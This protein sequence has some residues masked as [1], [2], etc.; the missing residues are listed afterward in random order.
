[1]REV[2]RSGGAVRGAAL[3]A[4]ALGAALFWTWS[5]AAAGATPPANPDRAES[6]LPDAALARAA[7][8]AVPA[9][10]AAQAQP[11]ERSPSAP[12]TGTITGTVRVGEQAV[13]GGFRVHL[14][15]R[16]S[17]TGTRNHD[18]QRGQ[19]VTD[20]SG[21]FHFRDVRPGTY[22]VSLGDDCTAEVDVAA[23]ALATADLRL[24]TPAIVGRVTNRG[25]VLPWCRIQ[26][27]SDRGADTG[28]VSR[29]DGGYH[30]LVGPGHYRIVITVPL[31]DNQ[32]SGQPFVAQRLEVDV[33]D[34]VSYVRRDIDLA[35][36]QVE[37]VA[38]SGGAVDTEHLVF[39]LAGC[40]TD[41][42]AAATRAVAARPDREAR[43]DLPPGSW[44]VHAR[45]R[46]VMESAPVTF[47]T[48]PSLPRTRIVVPVQPAG[49]IEL[50]VRRRGGGRWSP[51][52]HSETLL[53][54]LPRLVADKRDFPCMSLDAD[55][56][57]IGRRIGFAHVPVG[58]ARIVGGG[59]TE[60]GSEVE[61][62]PFDPIDPIEIDVHAGVGHAEVFVE[63]R[64]FV[65]LVACERGGREDPRGHIRVFAG[66]RLVRPA[67]SPEQSRWQA[68]LPP[69]EY[70]AAIERPD[71]VTETP[72]FVQR[73]SL[74]L[75]LRP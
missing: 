42:G 9:A 21:R 68:F 32:G 36:T 61:F 12:E 4:V 23:G 10:A 57:V 2:R 11:A 27:R 15:E 65:T 46:D 51:P 62:L 45:G 13:G 53:A 19:A 63:A 17:V 73:E 40:C 30:L 14:R 31:P 58:P 49:R 8:A 67:C 37:L 54:L 71:G 66:D 64:A 5:A 24:L 6:A 34:G 28:T 43:T 48:A 74:I 1:M 18:S 72:L 75:R 26:A 55:A 59:Q 41:E 25:E 35:L 70:R 16:S 56:V 60:R 22:T 50:D 69:G 44:T 38:E 29:P 20:T 7:P 33:P 39:E 47:E 3:A 52:A